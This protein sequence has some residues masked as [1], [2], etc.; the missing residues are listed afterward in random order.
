MSAANAALPRGRLQARW[1]IVERIHGAEMRA[2]TGGAHGHAIG[3]AVSR[4]VATAGR[5]VLSCAASSQTR[6]AL[7]VR[8]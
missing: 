6:R 5:F 1:L 4:F 2:I 3:A 7:L 8:G